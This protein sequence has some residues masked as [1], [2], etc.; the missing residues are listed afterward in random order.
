M[1]DARP[2]IRLSLVVPCYNEA[3]R[4]GL[5]YSGIEPFINMWKGELEII[6][7]NDGSKDDTFKLLHEHAVYQAH[8]NLITIISQ[9]N[10]GKGGALR[11]GVLH[12]RGDYILT[13]DADMASPP[14]EL[15]KWM[16]QM[17]WQPDEH[18]IY[19]G[20]RE[21]KDSVIKKQNNRKVAGN[22]F[23]LVVRLLI[24][25]KVKDTQCGFKLYAA[26]VAKKYFGS[27][28]TYGWAH[29]VEILY[30]A[31]LDK[32]NIVEMPLQWNAIDGSKISL[33]KDGL[34]MFLETM[35]IVI[36]T[37]KAFKRQH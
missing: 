24:P 31:Q 19:I 20:S 34:N 25:L 21:H 29:D 17:N 1:N 35:R 7:V 14:S 2:S 36:K 5:L 11:N 12:A 27:L 9:E 37:K 16:E 15:V 10:T 6:I 32:I 22:I 8:S 13:L 26:G 18:T 33:F 4:I 30:K 3:E 28:Q 23:N